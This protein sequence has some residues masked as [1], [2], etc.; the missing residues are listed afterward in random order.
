MN[1]VCCDDCKFM[2]WRAGE[3]WFCSA[4]CHVVMDP[5]GKRYCFDFEDG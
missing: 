1:L 4:K 2:E 5:I 3:G